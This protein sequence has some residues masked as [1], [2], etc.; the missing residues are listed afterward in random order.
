MPKRRRSRSERNAAKRKWQLAQ[1]LKDADPSTGATG[2]SV[3]SELPQASGESEP[4]QSETAF[5]PEFLTQTSING[6]DAD[7]K[8][9]IVKKIR[10]M[11]EEIRAVRERYP[12][13]RGMLDRIAHETMQ[14][15][16]HATTSTRDKLIASKL[17]LTMAHG[18]QPNKGLPAQLEVASRNNDGFDIRKIIDEM[19]AN[20]EIYDCREF[21][22]VPG[23]PE[24]YAE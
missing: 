8:G 17:L 9:E 11:W 23:S 3:P 21:K 18:N 19:N 10:H 12:I 14:T 24:D 15:M 16:L 7:G 20:R 5:A 13:S 1:V 22:I 2:V 6:D 4:L